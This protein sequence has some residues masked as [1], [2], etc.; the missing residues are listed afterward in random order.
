MSAWRD[1]VHSDTSLS[2]VFIFLNPTPRGL[3][4]DQDGLLF[5]L[6]FIFFF[7]ATN[8]VTIIRRVAP[9]VG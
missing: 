9:G 7:R 4:I 8:V 3:V 5:P 1:P 6:C 2:P